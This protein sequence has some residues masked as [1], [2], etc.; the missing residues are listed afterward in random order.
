VL[1]L[2]V[3][4]HFVSGLSKCKPRKGYLALESEGSECRFKNLKIK[5]LPSTNPKP[6]EIAAEAKG[7]RSL[8]N[9]LDL[10]GWKVDDAAR[11]HWQAQDTVLHFDG[12]SEAKDYSLR[13]EKEYA[14]AEFVADF[15]FP[16]RK[17][18]EAELRE[19]ELLLREGAEGA[20]T[21][22]IKAD[23]WIQVDG[24]VRQAGGL[25]KRGTGTFTSLKPAGQ[26][27]RLQMALQGESFRVMV[28]GTLAKE[29]NQD[30]PIQPKGRL[31]LRPKLLHGGEMD[32]A[33]LFVRELK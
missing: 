14:D 30:L 21:I 8:Y 15:R 31:A 20:M 6:V 26:W 17:D 3:N 23:G 7:H 32:F 1:N 12:K 22:T 24:Q 29:L 2:S 25:D 27:N 19:C 33:N 18:R 13:S 10:F 11:K 28:N 4:G 5:E 16:A 9:G